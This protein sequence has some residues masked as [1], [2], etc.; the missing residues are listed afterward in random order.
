VDRHEH[1]QFDGNGLVQLLKPPTLSGRGPRYRRLAEAL[2]AA[3]QRG[4]LPAGVLLPPER[5]LARQL[6]VSRSTVVAAYD[7][8]RDEQLVDRRQGSGTRVRNIQSPPPR[9]SEL[10]R[11]LRRPSLVTDANR[12][13]GEIVDLL[14]AYLLGTSGLPALAF[15]DVEA[16][17]VSLSYTAGYLPL[18]YPPLREAIA[19]HLTRRG[20]PTQPQQVLVTAGAQQAIHLGAWLY[21]Q[22]GDHVLVENPTYPGALDVF[23]AL[24]ARV[25]GVPTRRNGVALDRLAEL[26]EREAPR[27]MYLIP[28]YQ[29]P[30]GGV[31][32]QHGRRAL[33]ALVDSQQIPLLEDD[34]L[35]ELGI[36]GEPPSPVAS[37]SR[38]GPIL[39][40]GS[41]SKLCWAGLRI[42][43]L[44]GP[45]PVVTQL[46]RLK[47]AGDLG[48]SLPSQV[49][50]TRVFA[51]LD[52]FR[53]ERKPLIAERL[54]LVSHLLSSLLPAWSWD[55]P[56]GGLCLWVRLPYGTATEF[57]QVALRFGVSIVPGS[58]ASVDGSF[59][60]YL[61]LP[62]GHPPD[63]LE[64]GI[65]RLARAWQAYAPRGQA[66]G[67]HV[68]VIV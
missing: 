45:E 6:A 52:E 27:L 30:T 34:S 5:L 43:W 13:P 26:V 4:D 22:R 39:T 53:R 11:M 14:G 40:I 1:S 54:D 59:D 18:G 24:G 15:E 62:F 50:A 41:L 48:G 60:D 32:S 7:L 65:K 49:I 37:L 25:S 19:R 31:L 42:G 21:V 58:V 55:R 56:L 47:A 29:N 64:E 23:T 68:S 36:D 2:R 17:V 28:T 44:R 3:I 33:A 9:E 57:S 66:R 61:R 12:R 35:T 51:A 16:E 38:D 67:Q 10:G 8:L 20:L 46:G 63:V